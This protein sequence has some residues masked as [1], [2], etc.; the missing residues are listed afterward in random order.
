MLIITQVMAREKEEWTRPCPSKSSEVKE[1]FLVKNPNNIRD[2]NTSQK[3]SE[4][5]RQ[6][7]VVSEKHILAMCVA[8]QRGEEMESGKQKHFYHQKN[9]L[10][11]ATRVPQ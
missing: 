5:G 9:V 8:L 1:M 11:Q 4:R 3:K 6:G 2:G 10:N 7:V